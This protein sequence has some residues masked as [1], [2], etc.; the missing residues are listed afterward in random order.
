MD[1]SLT[2]DTETYM[3][4]LIG[5]GLAVHTNKETTA[6]ETSDFISYPARWVFSPENAAQLHRFLARMNEAKIPYHVVSR[7]QNWGYGDRNLNRETQVLIVLEKMNRIL[8]FDP[9]L[10]T[11]LIEP[12][13]SQKQLAD[14]LGEQPA[15]PFNGLKWRMDVTGANEDASIVGNFLERGFGHTDRGDHESNGKVIECITASAEIVFPHQSSHENSKTR[16]LYQHDTGLNLEKVFYQTNFAVVTKYLVHLKPAQPVE[17]GFVFLKDHASAAKAIEVVGHL[18]CEKV[19]ASVPHMAN[20]ARVAK[21]HRAAKGIDEKWVMMIELSGPREIVRARKKILRS[22]L[23]G[24]RI[25]FMNDL[26]V[27]LLNRFQFLFSKASVFRQQIANLNLIY[28]L[29]SGRPSNSFVETATR[30]ALG[31]RVRA[32]WM[33]PLFPARIQDFQKVRAI[34]EAVTTRYDLAMA[35]TISLVGDKCAVWVTEIHPSVAGEEGLKSAKRCYEECES[36]LTSAGYGFYR[37]G[38]RASEMRPASKYAREIK[39]IFDPHDLLSRG[40]WG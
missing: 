21:S 32:Q 9:E 12:G 11:V 4:S 34:I 37:Y 16:G 8:E 19:I 14:F 6:W 35:S 26:R 28:D 36:A 13:V 40:R 33:C 3:Q 7:G 29:Y 2:I 38:Y 25:I 18:K 15:S 17:F 23:S 31:A 27:K 30:D 22:S 5:E 24:S 20:G 1:E 10:G 39:E